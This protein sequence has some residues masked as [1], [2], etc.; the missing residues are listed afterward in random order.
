LKPHEPGLVVTHK[1][2]HR[3]NY[4]LEQLPV[5]MMGS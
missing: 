4:S 3:I 2:L 1:L 5:D